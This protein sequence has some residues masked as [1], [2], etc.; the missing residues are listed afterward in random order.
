[1]LLML[2]SRADRQETSHQTCPVQIDIVAECGT[3]CVVFGC[4]A[5]DRAGKE[6]GFWKVL[7]FWF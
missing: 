6:L 2:A 7:G 4:D 3:A 5:T 1:M